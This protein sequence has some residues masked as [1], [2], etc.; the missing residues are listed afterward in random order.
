M[1]D[2]RKLPLFSAY[3]LELVGNKFYAGST[4]S[5]EVSNRYQTHVRGEGSA[6]TNKYPPIR[7]I[8]TWSRLTSSEAFQ[9]EQNLTENLIEQHQDLEACRGG[10]WNFP[11]HT[12]W[13]VPPR[14]SH[15]VVVHPPL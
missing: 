14:L 4:L 3:L 11:E 6:W 1:K 8:Q 5:T 2:F 13:W 12:T 15:L 9:K 10:R 7:I